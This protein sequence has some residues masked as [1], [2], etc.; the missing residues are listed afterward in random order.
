MNKDSFFFVSRELAEKPNS[1]TPTI[2]VGPK[3]GKGGKPEASSITWDP[4]KVDSYTLW[5]ESHDLLL[6]YL[7]GPLLL[8]LRPR[9][10]HC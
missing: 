10:G 7:S 3:D 6:P 5:V 1:P 2:T 9:F 8:C 4:A